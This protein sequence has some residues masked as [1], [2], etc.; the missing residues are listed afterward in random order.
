MD[1][2]G[3]PKPPENLSFGEKERS[4]RGFFVDFCA[5]CRFPWCFRDLSSIFDEK[6][7][8]HQLKS[9]CIFFIAAFVFLN[10]A[11]LTKHRI[12]RIESYSGICGVFVFSLEKHRKIDSSIETARLIPNITENWSL[13]IC[14]RSK[15][16]PELPSERPNMPKMVQK[17]RSRPTGASQLGPAVPKASQLAPAGHQKACQLRSRIR[18]IVGSWCQFT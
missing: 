4:K 15:N 18:T 1:P 16:R 14:F 10:M 3:A 6:M 9:M 5:Q 8:K 7:M 11:T 2:E 17:S 12:L 13:G